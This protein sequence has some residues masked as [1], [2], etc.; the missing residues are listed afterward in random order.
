MGAKIFAILLVVVILGGLIY[1]FRS[2]VLSSGAGQ[3]N[4][5]IHSPS[6]S[7]TLVPA[8]SSPN[9]P[10]SPS[11]TYTYPTT[12]APGSASVTS[13][14]NP[15]DI[16]PGFTAKQLSPYFHLVRFGGV[17]PTNPYASYG[18]GSYGQ[19]TLSANIPQGGQSIDITGW[20]I[21]TNKGGEYVPQ[22][23]NVYD[24]SGLTSP[25]D[26]MFANGQVAYLYS[27][28]IP[29]NLR[30]NECIGYIATQNKFTPALPQNCP[31]QNR[32]AEIAGFTGAC[33]NFINSIGSCQVPNLNNDQVPQFDYQCRAYIQA[34][35]NYK[36]CFN[37]HVNDANF[38]SNQWWIWMGSSPLDQYHDNVYLFDR[39][40]LLVDTYSY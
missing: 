21:K 6:S 14:I 12:I 33:Q 1:L 27:T 18:S 25:S 30:L 35:F 8:T 5:L 11:Y 22:A 38:L 34:N 9:S 26:I 13:T 15:A 16:P 37:E 31:Y 24:P 7:F 19:I 10:S 32:S 39:N 28:Q 4:N 40:G 23:I 17:S 20:Q 29:F 3:I 2:G 36:T